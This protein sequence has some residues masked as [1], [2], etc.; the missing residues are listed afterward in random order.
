VK[1]SYG[2]SPGIK[3]IEVSDVSAGKLQVC[4]PTV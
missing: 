4:D 1:E 3:F 2:I